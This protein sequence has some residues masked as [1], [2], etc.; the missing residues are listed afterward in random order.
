MRARTLSDLFLAIP[1][2]SDESPD[3]PVETD[4]AWQAKLDE[5]QAG[6]KPAA[7]VGAVAVFF[8]G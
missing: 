3:D 5:R 1:T 6:A 4:A 8:E 7:Q 2:T